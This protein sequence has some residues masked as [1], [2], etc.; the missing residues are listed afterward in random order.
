MSASV[1]L[2]PYPDIYIDPV[3][4]LREAYKLEEKYKPGLIIDGI[5]VPKNFRSNT[6]TEI[7]TI[8]IRPFYTEEPCNRLKALWDIFDI[9]GLNGIEKDIDEELIIHPD[10]LAIDEKISKIETIEFVAIDFGAGRGYSTDQFLRDPNNLN[11]FDEVSTISSLALNNHLVEVL[12]TD[13][14]PLPFLTAWKVR[15]RGQKDLGIMEI[16][17]LIKKLKVENDEKQLTGND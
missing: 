15:Q 10:Y 4:L 1:I 9:S 8:N 7:L 16:S 2:N 17:S 13:N 5:R 6:K 14:W 3:N 11:S 12:G